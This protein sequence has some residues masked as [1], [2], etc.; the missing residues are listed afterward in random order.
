MLEKLI[1]QDPNNTQALMEMAMVYTLDLKEPEKSRQIL[2]RIIDVNPSHRAALNELELLYKELD[3][4][5]DGLALLELKAQ[6][7][8][9]SLEIQYVYG[10]M[11][12]SSDPRAAIPWLER[13]VKIPDQKEQALDQLASAAL[14]A[15]QIGLAVKSWSEALN[16]AELEL[17]QA[18]AKGESGTDYLEDRI[19]ATR[20]E[21]AK[22]QQQLRGT[23]SSGTSRQ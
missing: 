10:R 18:K 5:E 23:P 19:A 8:P 7:Y 3:A 17:E 22:A 4:V 13:A 6:Q 16:L 12:S 14:R 9:E 1:Q 15:G 11:L 20:S 2:E 21:L